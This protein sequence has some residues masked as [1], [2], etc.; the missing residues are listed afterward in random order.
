MAKKN[1][2]RFYIPGSQHE[3]PV[4]WNEEY[5]CWEIAGS[6]IKNAFEDPDID[7]TDRAKIVNDILKNSDIG[8]QVLPIAI[9]ALKTD[10]DEIA[11]EGYYEQDI[12]KLAEKILK[13]EYKVNKYN[14]EW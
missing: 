10:R 6:S 8:T 4:K 9:T 2:T 14:Y 13:D 1:D 5:E 12:L 11:F 7:S 3:C